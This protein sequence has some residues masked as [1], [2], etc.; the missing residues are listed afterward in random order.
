M[1][2]I[3]FFLLSIPSSLFAQNISG[4]IYDDGSTLEYV[5]VIN[6]TK[7]FESFSDANGF[8]TIEAIENDTILFSS[9]FHIDK[10]ILVTN[11]YLNKEVTI[12]LEQK[13]NNLEEVIISNY[14]F[15][16]KQFN[17]NFKNQILYDLDHNMQAY[18]Q[19]SNG[20][21]DF[22]KI[23]IR[24]NKLLSKNKK[25]K[26][27]ITPNYITYSELKLLFLE[28]GF[29]NEKLTDVL[30]IKEEN[31]DLFMDF[32]RGK[33]KSELLEEKNN[34]LLLDKLIDLSTKFKKLSAE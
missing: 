20:N 27:S 4:T 26:S 15:D 14:S 31:V 5:S 29:N 7:N 11:D 13:I 3:L 1:R 10:K 25:N 18:E 23:F 9:S 34:F 33:I 22:R 30:E 17:S 19:P 32:C 12:Q 21:V 16:E 2:L 8:F 24:A 6:I 28:Q